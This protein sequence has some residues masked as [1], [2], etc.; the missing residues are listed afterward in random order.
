MRDRGARGLFVPRMAAVRSTSTFAIASA[1][2][3]RP[4]SLRSFIQLGNRP[5]LAHFVARP[6]VGPELPLIAAITMHKLFIPHYA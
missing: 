6:M 4:R 5:N 3:G 2:S 1:L